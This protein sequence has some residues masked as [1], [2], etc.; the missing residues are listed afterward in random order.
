MKTLCGSSF[1]ALLLLA[2]LLLGVSAPRGVPVY[3]YSVVNDTFE[4]DKY[5]NGYGYFE[6]TK[7]SP[8]AIYAW[9]AQ[10]DPGFTLLSHVKQGDV[11]MFTY[12]KTSGDDLYNLQIQAQNNTPTTIA[13][14]YMK[15]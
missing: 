8:S 13:Y 14:Q 12:T 7:D 1:A 11:E 5:P 4:F 10:H 3:P 15:L 9:Y 2:P 6:E